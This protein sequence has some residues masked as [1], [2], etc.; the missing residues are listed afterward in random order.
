MLKIYYG[1]NCFILVVAN[2]ENNRNAGKMIE[3]FDKHDINHIN[4][5]NP[6]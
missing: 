6:V 5:S 3:T 4:Q 2:I 1:S